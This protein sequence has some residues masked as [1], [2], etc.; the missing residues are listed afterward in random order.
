MATECPH[1]DDNIIHVM[2]LFVVFGRRKPFPLLRNLGSIGWLYNV[3]GTPPPPGQAML[4]TVGAHPDVRRPKAS[5]AVPTL[6]VRGA[7]VTEIDPKFRNG[8]AG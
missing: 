6:H 7:G 1:D 5:A 4:S 8:V 3:V 2:M